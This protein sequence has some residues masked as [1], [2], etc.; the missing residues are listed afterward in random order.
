M[1]GPKR[2]PHSGASAATIRIREDETLDAFYRGRVLVL[3]RK[4]GYRFALDAPLLADFIRTRRTDELLEL[5]TGS[6]IISLLVG[7]R[8]TGPI[9]AVEIQPALADIA[10]R[11]VI[12]NRMNGRI[13]I[14]RRDFRTYRRRKK[15]DIVFANP[16]YIR[17]RSGF[18]SATAEK[19]VAKHELKCDIVEVMQAAARL[20]KDDGRAYFVF[21][22]R[23]RDDLEAAARACG[24]HLQAVR[25]VHP[26][27]SAEANL[28]LAECGFAAK[29]GRVLPPLVLYDDRGGTTAETRRIFEGRN[30]GPAH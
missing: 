14:V 7:L 20:L 21:P 9:T 10:R 26:R 17:K 27:K 12:L 24:L 30:R 1:P 3:Q 5:G 13:T 4:R 11:N 18:L 2:S 29:E 15:F 28:F 19:S 23:R 25:H 22:A 16:P 8:P 6:G